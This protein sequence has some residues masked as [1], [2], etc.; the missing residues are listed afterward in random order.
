M[1]CITFFN[2]KGGVGKSLHNVLFSSWLAY[3]ERVRVL[4]IE[5]ESPD[6]KIADEREREL[7]LLKD[8]Q[9]WLSRYFAIHGGQE[10]PFEILSWG[11]DVQS[12]DREFLCEILN[13]AWT[14]L[15]EHEQDYD[16]IVYD[17]PG[18]FIE[19][20]PAFQFIS[21]GLTDLVVV[22]F[23]T[24]PD[25]LKEALVN[26][27]LIRSNEQNVVGFWNCVSTEEL[28]RPGLLERGE[29]LFR[30]YGIEVL[31]ERVKEFVKARRD[32]SDRLFVKSTVC[33]PE[34]YV[35]MSCPVLPELY[36][37]IKRRLDAIQ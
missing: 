12:Y 4:L 17:F 9:S 5:L 25:T 35:Q 8:P 20:S 21:S 10:T 26:A 32:S 29:E 33:W 7:K 16:Y 34:R 2:G 27:D 31:P 11:K 24:N 6:P 13:R 30:Q 3:H 18:L 22:P 15:S 1:R 23:N 36:A 28:A 19:H 37:D 14:L